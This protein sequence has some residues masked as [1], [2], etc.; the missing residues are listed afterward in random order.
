MIRKLHYISLALIGLCLVTA[1]HCKG[2]IIDDCF[3]VTP[4]GVSEGILIPFNPP[5]DN[6]NLDA[7]DIQDLLGLDELPTLLY[8]KDYDGGAES[9]TFQ[10]SYDT[11]F[12]GEPNGATVVYVSGNA[13]DASATKYLVVKDG[14][15]G[16]PAQ[17]IFDISAWDGVEDIC[18]V[19]FWDGS[20]VQGA[21]SNLAIW[22]GDDDFEGEGEVPEPAS[23]LL[24]S[25]GGLACAFGRRI[26]RSKIAA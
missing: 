19:G 16:N 4:D 2:S 3:L 10:T 14:N 8:K 7:D 26:R 15:Q 17:Y 9:G 13:I 21:I 1:S 6:S 24:W 11:S 23:L 20:G 25:L 22:S 18:L 5:L 12:S